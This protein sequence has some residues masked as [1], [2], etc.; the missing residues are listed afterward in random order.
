M[1]NKSEEMQEE[2]LNTKI[3]EIKNL[4]SQAADTYSGTA[5]N[6][7][8]KTTAFQELIIDRFLSLDNVLQNTDAWSKDE[9]LEMAALFMLMSV[10]AD[11]TEELEDDPEVI[12]SNDG[13]DD[14]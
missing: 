4:L 5:N 2:L 10:D 9:I 11:M 8:L 6:S 3:E 14:V 1:S 12:D 13:E 7:F